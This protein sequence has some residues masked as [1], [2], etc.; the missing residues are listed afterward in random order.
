MR[1][2][3]LVVFMTLLLATLPTL[4][5]IK[6]NFNLDWK[7]LVDNDTTARL[8]SYDDASWEDI[9]LPHAFN[10]EQ[11]YSVSIDK[12]TGAVVW[13]RKTFYLPKEQKDKKVFIEFEGARQAAE[14][15]VNGSWVGL[16]ENG[17][18][19]FGF[20]L[21]DYVQFGKKP[22]VIAVRIDNNWRYRER[23]TNSTFQWNNNNFNANYGGLPKNVFLHVMEPV[24]QTLPLYSNLKT[25][26]VYVYAQNIDVKN[27]SLKLNVSSEVRNEWKKA[28][29]MQLHI[30]VKELDGTLLKEFSGAPFSILPGETK[31]VHAQSDLS[32][33]ELWSWGYGYLYDVVSQLREGN[34]VIDEVLIRTGFR[35]TAF[36]NGEVVLND[37]VLQMKG[38]AQRTSNEWPGVGMSVP[39]WLSDYSNHLMV[40]SNGNLIRWMHVTPW[41]QDVESCDRVGIIHA[42]PAGDAEK[43][44]QGR[45]WEHR[46]E[47]MRDAIIYNRNNPS[48][49]FYEGGNDDISEPHMVELKALRDQYDPYGGRAIGAREMLESK[50]AEYG[51]EMLYINKSAGKPVWAMEYCRDEALRLYWDDYSYPFHK[52]GDGPLYRGASAAAYNQNQDR[53]AME[54]VTRWYDYWRERPGTGKRVSSGGTSIIFSDS[55]TH[56]RG[57]ENYRRSGKVDA[58]RIAKDAFYAHQVMWDGWVDVENFRTHLVGH[59]NYPAGTVKPVYVISS[60]DRVELFLNQKSLGEGRQSDRFWF[61]FDSV[62]FEPGVLKAVSYKADGKK[63]SEAV[64][65]T[66]NEPKALKM[67]F[68]GGHTQMFADGA[69]M[70]LLEV[71]VVDTNGDRHPL[72]NHLVEYEVEGPAEWIGGLA[73][74]GN[75]NGVR[76]MKLPVDAGVNRVLL[77]ATRQAGTVR[78]KA[79]AAGLQPTE[80]SFD[81]LPISSEGGLTQ[82]IPGLLQQ[83]RL[84][85]G[86]T[87]STPS[88]VVSRQ[89]I[90]VVSAE[91]GA[92]ESDVRNAFDDNERSEWRNSG[93]RS[94]GWIVFKLERPATLD[95][96]TLKLT[97]WRNRSYNIRILSDAGE[98]LWEGRTDRSLG[99][100]TLP[101]YKSVSTESVRIELIGAGEEKD[102]FGA[103]VEV[104]EGKDLDL[105][106][107]TNP[108]QGDPKEELRI[109]EVEFYEKVK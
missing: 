94:T 84:D 69:D 29:Q 102:A 73:K 24:Y 10:E 71:E 21:T 48:I 100:I 95:E 7:L 3:S 61:T 107:K 18:M 64:L 79:R 89:A 109:V 108:D 8:A 65:S 41:K 66:I 82:H 104:E 62:S 83:P 53:F 54:T 14:I 97:G 31:Q 16:H 25:T 39:A 17:V 32:Q 56:Y 37:R 75:D 50:V 22:N 106:D 35:K 87:P 103:I 77:R 26:G 67:E 47:L 1:K 58:M 60:G 38:Y 74:Y 86:P 42:M 96:A 40:E 92:N 4:A 28:K 81:V 55:N 12:H 105:F 46:A 85:R 80:I 23:A 68:V 45:Q 78:V 33:V 11:A 43:D 98:V 13:Y 15:W 44:A 57:A 70:I 19:A 27:K 6:Y 76:S 88:Y 52:Q 36:E 49:L 30:M 51:G 63:L 90:D 99:Y 2:G 93:R 72:A 5:G 9:S 34:K 101:F 91:A 20:D 59:W